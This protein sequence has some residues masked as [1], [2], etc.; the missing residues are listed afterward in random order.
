MKN[1][2]YKINVCVLW[3]AIDLTFSLN[4]ATFQQ[5]HEKLGDMGWS[6]PQIRMWRNE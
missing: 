1:T 3:N 6:S 5:Q 4:V 2:I